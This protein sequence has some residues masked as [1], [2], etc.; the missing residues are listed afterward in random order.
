MPK[1]IVLDQFLKAFYEEERLPYA[2]AVGIVPNGFDALRLIKE[3]TTNTPS[4]IKYCGRYTVLL[5]AGRI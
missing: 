2:A 5:Y 1:I 4:A 3:T